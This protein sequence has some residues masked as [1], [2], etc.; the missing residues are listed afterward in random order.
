MSQ[1][2]SSTASVFLSGH[3]VISHLWSLKVCYRI[4]RSLTLVRSHTTRINFKVSCHTTLRSILIISFPL[5]LGARNVLL[6]SIY[7]RIWN[8]LIITP[9]QVNVSPPSLALTGNK[10]N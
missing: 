1:N 5:P 3:E 10:D 7:I 2:L 9:M 4:H 6:F 8:V